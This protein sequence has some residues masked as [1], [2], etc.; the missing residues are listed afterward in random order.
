MLSYVQEELVDI[1]KENI[2]ENLESGKLEYVIVKE[3][4]MDLKRKFRGRDDGT[5]KIV[6]LK[7]M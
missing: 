1:W 4:L 5:M 6:K 7:K 2:I 3:F